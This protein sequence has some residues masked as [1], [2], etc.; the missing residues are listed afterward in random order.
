VALYFVPRDSVALRVPSV[1][2]PNPR[3]RP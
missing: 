3:E 1:A 2:L